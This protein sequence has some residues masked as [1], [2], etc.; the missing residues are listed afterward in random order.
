V[1]TLQDKGALSIEVA[2]SFFKQKSPTIE[3]NMPNLGMMGSSSD[4]LKSEAPG[5]GK[6][7]I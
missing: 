2:K 4:M 6:Y 5:S 7:E 1:A 3:N